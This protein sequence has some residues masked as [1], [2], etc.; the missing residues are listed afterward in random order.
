MNALQKI[1]RCLNAP[2]A[3]TR[4]RDV[5]LA[6]LQFFAMLAEMAILLAA[7]AGFVTFGVILCGIGVTAW[8]FFRGHIFI[9]IFCAILAYA[10]YVWLVGL[11]CEFF[12]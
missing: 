11:I 12:V 2:V 7:L 1:D 10:Y 3:I 6:F 9:T 8:A 5:P 4:A